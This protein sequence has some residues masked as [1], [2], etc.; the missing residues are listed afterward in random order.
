LYGLV[1]SRAIMPAAALVCLCLCIE[2]QSS[3]RIDQLHSQPFGLLAFGLIRCAMGSALGYLTYELYLRTRGAILAPAAVDL[4]QVATFGAFLVLMATPLTN[5]GRLAM[6]ALAALMVLLFSR[7][8]KFVAVGLENPTLTKLGSLSFAVYLVHFPLL[9][10]FIRLGFLPVP[11]MV[12]KN[13]PAIYSLPIF[14]FFATVLG[15][16]FLTRV[17]VEVPCNSALVKLLKDI[18][19]RIILIRPNVKTRAT[20]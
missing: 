12:A 3:V 11:Q 7:S 4:M 6:I 13:G 10:A 15:T 19:W 9:C 18:P 8:G 20:T 14:A 2:M 17:L 1:R 5:V 16:A